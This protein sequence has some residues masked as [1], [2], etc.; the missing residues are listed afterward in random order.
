MKKKYGLK[1]TAMRYSMQKH[2]NSEKLL[3]GGGV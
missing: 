2:V 3:G 1:K